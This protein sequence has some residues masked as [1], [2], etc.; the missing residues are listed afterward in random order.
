MKVNDKFG[1]ATIDA[2]P[3]RVATVGFNEAD[4]ALA[5]GVRPVAVRQFLGSFDYKTRPWAP[6]QGAPEEV[7]GAEINYERLAS[8]RPDL[9]LG[10]YSFI[11]GG[12]YDKLSAIAPTVAQGK[13]YADGA[14]PWD[15]Q[16]LTTGRALGRED[17]AR[18]EVAKVKGEFAAARK[19]H[20]EFAGKTITVM[21]D[22]GGSRF[23]LNRDDLR[24]QF[25]ADLGFQ[26]PAKYS[27]R[28]FETNLSSEQLSLL[29]TDV[30]VLIT[31]PGSK[32][33]SSRLFRELEVA[34]E[35][36]VV[37]LA[38]DGTE[39][40]ALGYNSPLS[41]PYLLERIVPGLAAAVDGDPATKP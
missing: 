20:P 32:L 5:L 15:Q 10:I 29:D 27:E 16:L 3:K 17:R 12:D 25:F 9:I 1:T 36:R 24:S 41:R 11:K 34:R 18:R 30:I 35:G 28:G 21:Y 14:T 22:S 7:G 6:E 19:E 8:A 31:D 38:A 37:T 4:F 26:T 40:G 2:P 39:A 33:V 23:V 13:Q